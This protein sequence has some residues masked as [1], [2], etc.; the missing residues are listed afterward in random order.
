MNPEKILQRQYFEPPT[1]L[2]QG[3]VLLAV[4]AALH[5]NPTQGNQSLPAP[6]LKFSRL[7]TDDFAVFQRQI[8]KSIGLPVVAITGAISTIPEEMVN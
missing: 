4:G 2:A 5:H 3:P 6:F 8:K 1:P 7:P